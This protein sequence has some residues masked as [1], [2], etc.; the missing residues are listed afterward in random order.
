MTPK[1]LQ[2]PEGPLVKMLIQQDHRTVAKMA[3]TAMVEK[4]R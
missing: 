4:D 3:R 2:N 1:P